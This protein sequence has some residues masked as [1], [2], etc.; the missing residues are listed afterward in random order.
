MITDPVST[1]VK[2][3]NESGVL[4]EIYGDLAKP[5]VS[6]VGRALST[7]IGLGNTVLWPIY[8]LN[9]ISRI[10]LESN[11]QRYREKLEHV[12]LEK[13]CPIPPEVGVPIAEKLGYVTD[14]ELQEM[15]S[16]L[17]T[18]ASISDTQ[19]EAHPSF[20][21]V[22]NN[23][24]PDEALLLKQFMRNYG[25][26][27]SVR[28]RLVN[29]STAHWIELADLHISLDDD[30]NLLYP[31]NTSAYVRNLIGLG[32]LNLLQEVPAALTDRY[33]RIEQDAREKFS[34]IPLLDGFTQLQLTHGKVEVTRYGWMF[35]SACL[36]GKE[37]L[38]RFLPK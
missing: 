26:E 31:A 7:I 1:A 8:L 35:L 38:N 5:G 17:L 27:P 30:T 15:Y 23:I 21:N 14:H 32:V 20:V 28:I 12:P 9:E 3:L 29:P 19:S 10:K 37:P 11:L 25:V 16:A 4:K 13:V 36:G 6:Q 22:I 34:S 33:P 2:S 18:K 24:S